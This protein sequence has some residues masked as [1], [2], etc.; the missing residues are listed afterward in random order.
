[1]IFS[2]LDFNT[3][4]EGG[5]MEKVEEWKRWQWV[6]IFTSFI[7]SI[8]QWSINAFVHWTKWFWIAGDC[9]Q[10]SKISYLPSKISCWTNT[11]NIGLYS[12]RFVKYPLES[13]FSHNSLSPLFLP[14]QHVKSSPRT[15]NPPPRFLAVW[16]KFRVFNSFACTKCPQHKSKSTKRP[17]ISFFTKRHWTC[18]LMECSLSRQAKWVALS[19]EGP[20]PADNI[21][22]DWDK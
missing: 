7:H 2:W 11:L 5:T 14:F 3:G 18:Q 15:A 6:C 10:V 1:M 9:Q 19:P 8:E 20:V 17:Q 22:L 12:T 4:K 13:A 16:P 21:I